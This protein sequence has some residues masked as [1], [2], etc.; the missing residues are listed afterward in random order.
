MEGGASVWYRWTAPTDG[1]VVL[2]TCGS[3]FR[4][5]LAVYTG[6]SVSALTEVVAQDGLGC[7][8]GSG[9]RVGFEA[10][11]ATAYSIVVDGPWS[12]LEGTFALHLE[13]GAQ[14][15]DLEVVAS[16]DFGRVTVGKSMT[17]TVVLENTGAGPLEVRSVRLRAYPF[18][19]GEYRIIRDEATGASIPPTGS[20]EVV[21]RFTPRGNA[22]GRPRITGYATLLEG[23]GR[24][25]QSFVYHDEGYRTGDRVWH[26]FRNEGGTG[27]VGYRA[28]ASNDAGAGFV[29]SGETA[30]AVTLKAGEYYAAAGLSRYGVSVDAAA[31]E[32]YL[33]GGF[34]SRRVFRSILPGGSVTGYTGVESV[35]WHRMGDAMLV[36]SSSDPTQ[37]EPDE[38]YTYSPDNGTLAGVRVVGEGR[39]VCPGYAADPRT[40][41]VGTAG[42]D[43]LVGTAD[44]DIL[45]GLGGG[46]VLKGKGGRDLLIGGPGADRVA[47]ADGADRILVRDASRDV[48][49]GGAGPDVGIGDRRDTWRRV[50]R[51]SLG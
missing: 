8:T 21:L 30:G 48:V 31:Q 5:V 14:P 7:E 4:T 12:G 9:A 42:A 18:A 3:D 36:I 11:A 1:P 23:F 19:A 33:P 45:C 26:Y 38:P 37:D 51:I 13:L 27:S 39:A 47:G 34:H 16:V 32:L 15:G 25:L 10:S 6:A 46:D 41:V 40:Q 43:T 49:D 22:S 17:R 2:D 44:N 50:E 35:T 29:V 24:Y 20:R 28:V